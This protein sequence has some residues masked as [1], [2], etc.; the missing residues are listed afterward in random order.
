MKLSVSMEL[1]FL[2]HTGMNGYD[3][4]SRIL[5]MLIK[6]PIFTCPCR[7]EHFELQINLLHMPLDYP[8][9]G[10]VFQ[11]VGSGAYKGCAFCE[12]QGAYIYIYICI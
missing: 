5:S 10:K 3:M 6:S 8:A 11:I 7:K 12:I 2:I 9:V 1:R 4:H